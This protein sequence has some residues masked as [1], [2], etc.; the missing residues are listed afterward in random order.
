MYKTVIVDKGIWNAVCTNR[1]KDGSLYYVDTFIKARFDNNKLIGFSSIRQDV[2]ELKRKEME[3]SNRMNAI[4]RSNAVIE[5]DLDGN[6]RYAND[7]FLST[8]GYDSHD[9]LVGK[10]HSIFV[11]DVVKDSEEYS[12][13]WKTLK[14]GMQVHTVMSK[15]G[16]KRYSIT[17]VWDNNKKIA[18][19]VMFNPSTADGTKSD[20]TT[21]RLKSELSKQGFGGIHIVNL[22]SA[23]ASKPSALKSMSDEAKGMTSI[24]KYL[25]PNAS[26]TIAAWGGLGQK[27]S[28][29]TKHLQKYRE[30][31]VI[32]ELQARKIEL[33]AF[34]TT[35]GGDPVHPIY[36]KRDPKNPKRMLGYGSLNKL[37][38]WKQPKR[39]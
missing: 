26:V 13:F 24:G 35:K 7:L 38:N 3:I 11:E 8:L 17:Q 25:N 9:E 16:T 29:G 23:R 2:T 30:L 15:D 12:N 20:A 6:I 32:R 14:D 28:T 21:R 37:V 18:Q 34:A 22:Y 33:K 39:K 4:N 31:E 5:F 19:L 36:Q 1:K 27:S 10:H